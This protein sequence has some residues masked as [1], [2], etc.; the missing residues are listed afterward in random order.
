[1]V[2]S[3]C[4]STFFRHSIIILLLFLPMQVSHSNLNK[5]GLILVSWTTQG[6]VH[7]GANFGKSG[8]R[9]ELQRQAESWVIDA[10]L[11]AR[12]ILTISK[13]THIMLESSFSHLFA[14]IHTLVIGESAS[15]CQIFS[16][17]HFI[18][19]SLVFRVQERNLPPLN[20]F[21]V[22]ISICSATIAVEK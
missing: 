12:R 15:F 9:L 22:S 5:T 13:I 16:H 14:P 8:S 10:Q 18:C 2:A 17:D 19:P 4:V 21:G 3:Y 6:D 11:E 20:I 1:M 7:L